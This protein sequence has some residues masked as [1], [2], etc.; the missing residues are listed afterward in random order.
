MVTSGDRRAARSARR[1][2]PTYTTAAGASHGCGTTTSPQPGPAVAA[3]GGDPEVGS[4]GAQGGVAPAYPD[5]PLVEVAGPGGGGHFGDDLGQPEPLLRREQGVEEQVVG[6]QVGEGVEPLPPG[7]REGDEPAPE[8]PLVEDR[9]PALD[10]VERAHRPRPAADV[11]PAAGGGH[12]R[13]ARPLQSGAQ[14]V[15]TG[16]GDD[17]VGVQVEPREAGG[18]HVSGVEGC[19][20]AGVRQLQHAHARP[21]LRDVDGVVGAAVGRDHDLQIVVHAAVVDQRVETAADHGGLV[22]GGDHDGWHHPTV[23][24][25]SGPAGS[26]ARVSLALGT[27]PRRRRTQPAPAEVGRP[28]PL[29]DWGRRASLK[30]GI[31]TVHPPVLDPTSRR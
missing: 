5:Q 23:T 14:P 31:C 28:D 18:H 13:G 22:V 7:P 25:P 24:P 27:P 8:Q 19:G 20:L 21:R 6:D 29:H 2:R 1:V 15:H 17:D 11:E 9:Q 4:L 26:A 10:G 16:P 12:Q 3:A 30:S